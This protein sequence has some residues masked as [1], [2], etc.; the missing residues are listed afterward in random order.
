MLPGSIIIVVKDN[1]TP[2]SHIHNILG[3]FAY[4]YMLGDVVV[5]IF[6]LLG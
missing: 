1:F 3:G 5:V 4:C 6:I 2:A